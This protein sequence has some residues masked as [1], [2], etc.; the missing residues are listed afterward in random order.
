MAINLVNTVLTK[1]KA[2]TS[3]ARTEIR[4][5]EG[6]EKKRHQAM[7]D[8]T[9]KQNS[10]IDGQL[11]QLAK[12][13]VALGVVAGAAAVLSKGFD[14]LATNTR[15]RAATVGVSME[16]L[17]K[18]T[19][20]LVDDTELMT[21]AASAMNGTFKLTQEQMEGA[22]AGA[23][24]LRK[25]MG[26]P[27]EETMERVRKAVTEGSV[28]PLKELGLISKNVA[29]DSIEGVNEALRLLAEQSRE[30]GPDLRL[31]GDEMS[32]AA[33]EME[34]AM[35]SLSES[36]GKLAVALA[37]IVGALSEMVGLIGDIVSL[38]QD[39]ASNPVIGTVQDLLIGGTAR[40]IQLARTAG[41]ESQ[42]SGRR[43]V[44]SG[45]E[46]DTGPTMFGPNQTPAQAAAAERAGRLAGGRRGG[47]GR[48]GGGAGSTGGGIDI[49][50][51]GVSA[52]TGLGSFAGGQLDR[53]GA[54][55]AQEDA[56]G[57]EDRLAAI[58]ATEAFSAA[59]AEA[60]EWASQ[61]RDSVLT[62][63]FGTPAEVDA[64]LMA[65]GALS[66][67]FDG[68]ANAFGAG[69]D[70]L[71]T[72]S[73]SFA[74]AFSA[75][76]GETLRAMSVDM[77]IRAIRETAMGAAML[78]LNPAEAGAHFTA[79]GLY[80]GGAAIAGVAAN[81]LGAGGGLATPAPSRGATGSA[82][83]GS[84]RPG[85]GNQGDGSSTTVFILDDD[86]TSLPAAQ[87]ESMLR[88]RARRAGI[89]VSGDVIRDG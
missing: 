60:D 52:V 54:R 75:A 62:Q 26:K 72:G 40:N 46:E 77:A 22:L 70:A 45:F 6:A 19:R 4:K 30:A 55:S 61:E 57:E 37:P 83:V 80:A 15:L 24:A 41:A 25:T 53:I 78:F 16:G 1:F 47:R 29:N 13:G 2:N 81:Q 59:R 11:D 65:I 73:E 63:I 88:G 49:F 12:V 32:E 8:Q 89:E 84:A 51:A 44:A 33:I 50:G 87:R 76:I 56:I 68:F 31:P 18:S 10:A 27:L 23:V 28:E 42:L 48:T 17:R 39:L 38:A 74:A 85:G 20:N 58:A 35:D 5:L 71:I 14:T 3:Q 34:N 82:G 67:S 7:I 86:F 66:D 9:E 64:H 21:F 69:V 36:L 43:L 79:A